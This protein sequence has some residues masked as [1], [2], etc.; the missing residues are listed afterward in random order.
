MD[1]ATGVTVSRHELL[2]RA[3]AVA[4]SLVSRGCRSGDV[5]AIFAHNSVEW[6]VLLAAALR[7]DAVVAGINA[8]LTVGRQIVGSR[9]RLA[10]W[11]LSMVGVCG[12]G[13][14]TC[15]SRSRPQ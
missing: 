11:Q 13:F 12:Y 15:C 14:K 6:V 1:A 3:E 4:A 5:I 2:E 8:L 10:W 7:I 9:A